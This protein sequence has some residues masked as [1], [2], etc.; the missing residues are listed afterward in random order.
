MTRKQ[1]KYKGDKEECLFEYP[2]TRARLVP[3]LAQ[4]MVYHLASID[5]IYAW[6][7]A[8]S[9]VLDL[10]NNLIEFL[11][12]ISSV[13]KPKATWFADRTINECRQLMGGHGFSA[14]SKMATLL[15]D[16]HINM[17]W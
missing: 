14:F 5:L 13:M 3:L 1:F 7:D 15:N 2:L 11:H 10:K 8:G 4:A 6:D 17:T 16:N 12:A 9:S